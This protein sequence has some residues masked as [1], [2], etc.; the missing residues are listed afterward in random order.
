MKFH[1]NPI[2]GP[3]TGVC[4]LADELC[5]GSLKETD[6]QTIKRESQR[7]QIERITNQREGVLEGDGGG[8]KT[9]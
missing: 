8:A 9:V 4:S 6:W 3:N 7:R 2:T 1:L 5:G